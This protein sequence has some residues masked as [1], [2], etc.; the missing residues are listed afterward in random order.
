MAT[1]INKNKI[2]SPAVLLQ[3]DKPRLLLLDFN[4]MAEFQDATGQTMHTAL[5]WD[6]KPEDRK[7][8]SWKVM[9]DVVWAGLVSGSDSE[10]DTFTRKQVGVMIQEYGPDK[11][12]GD[13]IQAF[14]NANEDPQAEVT[15]EAP[16][17]EGAPAEI[18]S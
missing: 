12:F 16:L 7:P 17:A 8:P 5:Q 18:A 13:L 15:K 3:L 4:A 9:R 11:V 2:K 6:K 1:P 10:D 14:K